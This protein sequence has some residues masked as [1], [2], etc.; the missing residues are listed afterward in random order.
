MADRR[1]QQRLLRCVRVPDG[2]SMDIQCA[3]CDGGTAE[4]PRKPLKVADGYQGKA[5]AVP[6]FRVGVTYYEAFA[7]P[8]WPTQILGVPTRNLQVNPAARP[9]CVGNCHGGALQ[10]AAGEYGSLEI[11]GGGLNT[12]QL[13]RVVGAG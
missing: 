1:R 12:V 8:R 6:L 4:P 10:Q 5:A 13:V 2:M 3:A 11:G 7:P 9:C